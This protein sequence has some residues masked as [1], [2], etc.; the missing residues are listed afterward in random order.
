MTRQLMALPLLAFLAGLTPGNLS[1]QR[2]P[3]PAAS[4][5]DTI[6]IS[7]AG[8]VRSLAEGVRLVRT[9][10]VVI[11]EEGSYRE[12]P[13]LID[14][15]VSIVGRGTAVLH[16]QSGRGILLVRSN[17]V[18]IRGLQLRGVEPS[19]T[20]DRAAIRVAGANNC[21]IERNV[22]DDNFFGVFLAEVD[23][24][25]VRSNQLRGRGGSEAMSG[26]GIHV[27]SS[28]N[29]SIEQNGITNHR[30]GI[31]LEFA[32]V[33]RI[34]GNH[35]EGNRRYGLHFMFSDDS[36]FE[37]NV[38]RRNQ[39]GVAVMYT[40]RVLMQGN[41]F[42]AN[43]GSGA[44]G[45][46]LKEITDAEVRGNLFE[47][48]TTALLADGATR[49]ITA[50]NRFIGNGWALRLLASSTNARIEQNDFIGNSFDVATNSRQTYSTF[51]GNYW[52]S[53]RGYDLNRD[54]TGD[55][56]HRPVRLFSQLVERFEPVLMLQRSFLVGLLD[57]AERAIPSITPDQMVDATPR[58]RP[59]Q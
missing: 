59:H 57:A 43:W 47:R 6:V 38:F 2:A 7:P 16:A 39:A 54:G 44:Y 20:E 9:G 4:A 24:C 15:A 52:D 33:S 53:Y 12:P 32:A 28:G 21:L 34:R 42:E 19:E 31:Y 22:F 49:L 8:A 29:V 41:R 23:G 18:T 13:V 37:D 51:S 40:R 45:L 25:R 1:S 50:G 35:V 56:P 3:T 46:L 30:D 55:V 26:N 5:P 58:M 17:D 10:G 27:W 48:N 14:R 36:H 11:V